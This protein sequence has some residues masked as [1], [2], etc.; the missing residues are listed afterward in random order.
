MPYKDKEK[1]KQAK[2]KWFKKN[3][4]KFREYQKK[5]EEEHKAKRQEY[6]RQYNIQNKE[7]NK[8]KSRKHY[9]LHKE[10]VL[11]RTHQY[12]IDNKEKHSQWVK[13]NYQKNK[14]KI[15]IQRKENLKKNINLKISKNLRKRL[16]EAIKNNHKSATTLVL[17]GC[18]LEELKQYL[19][20]QFKEG[21]SWE[22]YGTGWFGK[23]MQEWHI[24][25]IKPC[26]KFDLTDPKQQK[27]CFNY[28]NL[29]PL[30]AEENLIK[31]HY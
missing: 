24:D 12:Y 22:N 3:K 23:G 11:V 15:R 9:L 7:K 29:Q 18:S 19:E 8:A 2:K 28:K 25:H 30:W 21:M 17:L 4:L 1:E 14:E 26:A 6:L 20:S 13:D 5:W 10:E 16:W 31:N 27:E